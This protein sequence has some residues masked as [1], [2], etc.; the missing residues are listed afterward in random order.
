[1]LGMTTTPS[2]PGERRPGGR[3]AKVRTAVLTATMAA[4]VEHGY[5]SL[6][7]EDVAQRAGVHKTTVYRRWPS[8]AEL[9]ADAVRERSADRVEV[10]DTGSFAGDLA[11]LARAVVANIGS[12]DGF[13]MIQN[14]MVVTA[15]S[16]A[17]A[18][19]GPKFWADR[20]ELTGAIVQRAIARGELPAAVDANLII[21]TLIGPLYIR[22]LFTGEP[23]DDRIADQ[24]ARIVAAGTST[25]R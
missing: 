18:D 1:M 24:V 11:A 3:T 14:L 6:N 17:L 22:L 19:A 12:A 8:K 16:D 4:L 23:I 13:A 15:A 10:P 21:E 20:L 5:E 25:S 2:R 9:V 7:V